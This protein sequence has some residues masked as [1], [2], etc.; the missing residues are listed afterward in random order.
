MKRF[1]FPIAA[2][3]AAFVLSGLPAFLLTGCAGSHQV[4]FQHFDQSIVTVAQWGGTRDTLT[5]PV[6]KITHITL[7][8]GGV[9][10]TKDEDPR[11]YLR[12]LQN[13]SR[14][15]KKWMD[16]PYHYLIDL[17]GTIYEGRDIRY[18]GDTNTEYDP[19]G[20]ALICVL[21]NYENITPTKK[22]LNSIVNLFTWLCLKYHLSPDVIKGHKDYSKITVC[23]GKNL[24]AYLADG[25]FQRKVEKELEHMKK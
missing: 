15:E 2:I 3:S 24:Y 16:I 18:A 6:Q 14:S 19:T 20:H 12:N 23:P 22:Q 8:H 1:Y 10:F 21:G 17:D 5:H 7:H 9:D 11:A 13:W 25:Y 4:D